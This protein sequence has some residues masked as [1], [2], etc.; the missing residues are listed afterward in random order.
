MTAKDALILGAL[1]VLQIATRMQNVEANTAKLNLSTR[2]KDV[3]NHKRK[4]SKRVVK[5]TM[6]TTHRW[7]GNSAGRFPDK[8]VEKKKRS[9]KEIE[10]A[11]KR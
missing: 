1:S 11:V 3:A 4:K 2:I 10:K 8:E 7:F 6:C 5:C 9:K